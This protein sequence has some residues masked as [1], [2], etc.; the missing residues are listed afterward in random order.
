MFIK[1]NVLRVIATTALAWGVAI[2]A[3]YAASEVP[4]PLDR[5][6]AQAAVAD[7]CFEI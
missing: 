1:A 5:E 3:V 2:A 6:Q 7:M 4:Q